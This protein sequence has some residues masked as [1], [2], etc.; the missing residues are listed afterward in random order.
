MVVF[1]PVTAFEV[2]HAEARMDELSDRRR[3]KSLCC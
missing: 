2:A 3:S 1:V